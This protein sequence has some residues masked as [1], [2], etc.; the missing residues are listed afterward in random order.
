MSVCLSVCLSVNRITQKLTV[1]IFTKSYGMVGHNSG[2]TV[3]QILSD[4]DP[5]STQ[6]VKLTSFFYNLTT[7]QQCI[8]AATYTL[9]LDLALHLVCTV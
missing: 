2:T 8:V 9:S 3:D 5:N 7:A 1:Q 4:L 6:M